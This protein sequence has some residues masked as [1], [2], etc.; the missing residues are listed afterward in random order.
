[1][2]NIDNGLGRSIGFN[3]VLLGVFALVT[4]L[5]LA[6]TYL[7]T[8]DRIAES[9]RLL[10][11]RGLL[12]LYPAQTHDNDLLADVLP[13][14]TAYL[15]TLGLRRPADIHVVRNGNQVVGFIVPA[16]APDGY[17]GDIDMIIGINADGTLAGVRVTSH[18][19][20]P[21]LGD[22]IELR[23]H[24]WILSF[25]GRSLGNPSREQWTVAKHGGAFDQ[26]TGATITPRAVVHKVR[27]ALLFYS[28]YGDQLLAA[29]SG[30][31]TTGTPATDNGEQP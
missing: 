1:M 27:D 21:G 20:T 18:R 2:S 4:S 14:P 25:D 15:K 17:S 24:P 7:N 26:F 6:G 16:V 9:E 12:E 31:E 8:R 30:S 22:K 10:A 13:V 11:Q 5:L 29:A 23:K 28:E 19:E 3:S